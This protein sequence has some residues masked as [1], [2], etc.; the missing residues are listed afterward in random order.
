MR[1]KQISLASFYVVDLTD[2]P[3]LFTKPFSACLSLMVVG[4][5]NEDNKLWDTKINRGFSQ[6]RRIVA[7][8]PWSIC[9]NLSVI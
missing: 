7:E 2:C 9:P 6:M 1:A 8:N 5:L 3:M 4:S